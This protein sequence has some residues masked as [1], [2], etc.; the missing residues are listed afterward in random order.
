MASALAVLLLLLDA[1]A[2]RSQAPPPTP[3]PAAA[4]A[5][6]HQQK[7]AH[8]RSPSALPDGGRQADIT[9]T[10]S[11]AAVAASPITEIVGVKGRQFWLPA[12]NK[13]F[14]PGGVNLYWLMGT[15]GCVN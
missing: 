6:F 2:A 14:H 12:S 7:Y 11:A 1:P 9:G 10:I 13:E 8:M 5:A 15:H 4:M 3:Y